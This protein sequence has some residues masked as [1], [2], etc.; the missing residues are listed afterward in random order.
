MIAKEVL[1]LERDPRGQ[2]VA[3]LEG[4]IQLQLGNAEFVERVQRF[5]ALYQ[6]ELGQRAAEVVRVDLR[7]G[8]GAAVAFSP[9]GQL[10]GMG[11]E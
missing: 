11:E 5:V 9:P 7:Y 10:A 1:V 6:R 4:G 3:E 2:L 8:S